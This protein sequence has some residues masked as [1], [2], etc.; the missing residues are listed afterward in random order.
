MSLPILG[1]DY[2]ID[3]DQNTL[4]Y[5]LSQAQGGSTDPAASS[6]DQ[7]TGARSSNSYD[8]GAA[9]ATAGVYPPGHTFPTVGSLRLPDSPHCSVYC[10]NAEDCCLGCESSQLFQH[11]IDEVEADVYCAECWNVNQIEAKKQG[12]SLIGQ[13]VEVVNGEVIK[14]PQKKKPVVSGKSE[15]VAAKKNPLTVKSKKRSG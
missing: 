2:R 8:T 10:Y 5:M 1:G 3:V 13:M 11:V 15:P 12:R 14:T 7:D 9:A 4:S 6:S